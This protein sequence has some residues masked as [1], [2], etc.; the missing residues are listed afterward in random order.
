MLANLPAKRSTR[1]LISLADKPQRKQRTVKTTFKCGKLI[2]TT[3]KT[4]STKLVVKKD[5]STKLDSRP[6]RD[7]R[8]SL[9]NLNKV[10]ASRILDTNPTLIVRR[11]YKQQIRQRV[12]KK[13]E[14]LR[15]SETDK[16]IVEKE[17][18]EL[19]T[20]RCSPRIV[21]HV[22]QTKIYNKMNIKRFF[23]IKKNKMITNDTVKKSCGE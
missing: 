20:R 19:K 6:N 9:R 12:V 11:K 1:K 23:P 22:E 2:S 3:T 14:E 10:L 18:P 16:D 5:E 7:S 21:K 15:D 4:S 13:N 17:E 8:R